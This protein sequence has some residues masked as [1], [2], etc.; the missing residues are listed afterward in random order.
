MFVFNEKIMSNIPLFVYVEKRK[1]EIWNIFEKLKIQYHPHFCIPWFYYINCIIH[2]SA[3]WAG[4]ELP[5]SDDVIV[6]KNDIPFWDV[7]GY[8]TLLRIKSVYEVKLGID[9][10]K[11]VGLQNKGWL[12]E[13][14]KKGNN[15]E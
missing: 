11:W 8:P 5:T 4:E 12:C 7:G 13:Q 9:E 2:S 10:A 1:Y 15:V 3:G 14:I 6:L